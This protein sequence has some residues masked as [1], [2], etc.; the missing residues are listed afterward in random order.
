MDVSSSRGDQSRRPMFGRRPDG[1]QVATIDVDDVFQC[2]PQPP[3]M[4]VDA[5]ALQINGNSPWQLRPKW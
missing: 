3:G 5:E 4:F 2:L 1:H